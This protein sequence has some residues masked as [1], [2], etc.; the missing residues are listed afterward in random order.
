MAFESLEREREDA[1][2]AGVRWRSGVRIVV[3]GQDTDDEAVPEEGSEGA[4]EK[5]RSGMTHQLVTRTAGVIQIISLGTRGA[6]ELRHC[7][8]RVTV[9]L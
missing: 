6:K 2:T 5:E 8:T 9:R 3:V 7:G 4:D 1:G